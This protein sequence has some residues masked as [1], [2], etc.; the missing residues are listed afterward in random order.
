MRQHYVIANS[1]LDSAKIHSRMAATSLLL[2]LLLLLWYSSAEQQNEPDFEG[3]DDNTTM[4]VPV[5]LQNP[6][7]YYLDYKTVYVNCSVY[8]ESP[9]EVSWL[10]STDEISNRSSDYT[11]I[12]GSKVSNIVYSPNSDDEGYVWWNSSLL[13]NPIN[14]STAGYYYCRVNASFGPIYSKPVYVRKNYLPR[15]NFTKFIKSGQPYVNFLARSSRQRT[16]TFTCLCAECDGIEWRRNNVRLPKSSYGVVALKKELRPYHSINLKHSTLSTSYF[17]AHH[18]S[19]HTLNSQNNIF[20]NS[21]AY[22]D[23][24]YAT[25]IKRLKG[26]TYV[27]GETLTQKCSARSLYPMT[28]TWQE[29]KFLFARKDKIDSRS[30]T[31]RYNILNSKISVRI[32]LLTPHTFNMWCEFYTTIYYQPDNFTKVHGLYQK[33]LLFEKPNKSGVSGTTGYSTM[34]VHYPSSI[35]SNVTNI[36]INETER[37]Y[38]WCFAR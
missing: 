27:P 5:M 10:Y 11:I 3:D 14:N 19:C 24:P 1:I 26:S 15:L 12:S 18:Y 2:S 22:I 9:F 4:K 36:T 7:L 8:G 20:E 25:I 38:L 17:D 32:S 21:R 28:V 34:R 13:L 37:M 33:G 31:G 16:F 35:T 30:T 6:F 29:S 23:V